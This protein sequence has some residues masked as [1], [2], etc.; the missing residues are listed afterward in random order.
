MDQPNPLDAVFIDAE[1]D[2]QH[3]YCGQVTFG[4]TGDFAANPDL[5]VLA[6]GIEDGIIELR[7]AARRGRRAARTAARP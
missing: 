2:N 4:V 1:D 6:R 7:A 3:T 5:D